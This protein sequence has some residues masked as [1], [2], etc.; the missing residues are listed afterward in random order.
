MGAVLYMSSRDVWKSFGESFEAKKA[1]EIALESEKSANA[2]KTRFLAAASH[3]LRQPLHA[4]SMFSAA[5]TMGNLDEQ[6]HSIATKMNSA[7]ADL[8]SELDS[9][10]D[11]SKLDAGVMRVQPSEFKIESSLIRMCENFTEI[12]NDK[13][14]TL[15]Q[16]HPRRHY[17]SH[18]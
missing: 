3:D 8:S 7:M 5:L 9:L 16:I 17:F 11:I 18:G 15:H 10:L 6:N 14:L 4:M 2:A 12:A 13:N 1:L